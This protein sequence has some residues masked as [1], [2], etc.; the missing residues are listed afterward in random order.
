MKRIA[1]LFLVGSL[2]MLPLVHTAG[3]QQPQ[4]RG[5]Q[6]RPDTMPEMV[7]PPMMG[8]MQPMYQQMMQNPMF[9]TGMMVYV[10]PA[11]ADTLGLSFEQ[12][13]QLQQLQQQ[14]A[15]QQQERQQEMQEQQQQLMA[16]F[17]GDA[18]PDSAALREQ[19]Q[20]L[21]DLRAQH[22]AARYETAMQMRNVLTEAQRQMVEQMD[23]RALHR[24]MMANMTVMDMMQMMRAMRG[25]MVGM[26]GA[27][28]MQAMP[29]RYDGPMHQP[30]M[31]RN[32]Q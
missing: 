26:G 17:E 10:L 19:L 3:A 23:Q 11:L 28:R 29:M 21:A 25:G 1:A 7:M 15:A 20:A 6:A 4:Q 12:R 16:L 5:Q 32:Q 14:F 27:G 22:Q 8:V 30:R 31:P 9:R 2:L 24:H 18:Q 13:Q